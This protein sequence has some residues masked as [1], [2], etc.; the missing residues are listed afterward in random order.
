M[1][2][3]SFGREHRRNGPNRKH[4][5]KQTMQLASCR[6]YMFVPIYARCRHLISLSDGLCWNG[7]AFSVPCAARAAAMA[8]T[9][10][11]RLYLMINIDLVKEERVPKE[12]EA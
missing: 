10:A 1:R 12:Q 8:V 3:S 7:S 11:R 2:A 6:L 9:S 5:P 4:S